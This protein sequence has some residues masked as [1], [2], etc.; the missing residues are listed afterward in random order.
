MANISTNNPNSK[1]TRP[2]KMWKRV[3]GFLLGAFITLAG[4]G[5]VQDGEMA[6][7]WAIVIGGIFMIAAVMNKSETV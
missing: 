7:W 5:G 2:V 4:V 1:L 3:G 6:A